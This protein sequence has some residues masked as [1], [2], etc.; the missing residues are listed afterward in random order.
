MGDNEPTYLKEKILIIVDDGIAT[1]NTLQSTIKMLRHKKPAKI[2]IAAPVAS[3][4]S[5]DKLSKLVDEMVIPLIPKA[6]YGVGGFY[7]DFE[8][9]SDEE[10]L[11][12][13][14]MPGKKIVDHKNE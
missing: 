3:Q 7:E 8:Q 2:V 11:S 12:Y 9:V 14:N 6:F 10:V 1:G 4:S 13:L 5:V